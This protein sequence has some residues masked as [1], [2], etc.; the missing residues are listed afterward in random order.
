MD[1]ALSTEQEALVAATAEWCRDN[2][3]LDQARN[4]PDG[5]WAELEAMG[6]TAMT[7]PDMGLDHASETLV[8]AE[9][10][11]HLAPVGL[12]ASA[13]AARWTPHPGK[14]TLAL[15]DTA[16]PGG[17]LRVFDPEDA[18][19]ALGLVGHL[20]A[21]TLLPTDFG[22]RPS[23][24]PS[25]SLAHIDPA[26][27]FEAVAD[28]R[29]ALHLQLLAASYAVGCADA[30]RD[31]AAGYALIREQFERPIGWF[32]ALKHLCL[33]MAVRCAVARSQ[34]CYAACALNADDKDVSFHVA[35]A[36]QLADQAAL[37]NGRANIQVHGGIGM[38]DEA[39][40]HL[41]LKRAHLLSFIAP[42]RR[43]ILLGEAA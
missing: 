7:A 11:R 15:L 19:R 32:Q 39:S 10:G 20:A 17:T 29:A 24:D 9:L 30:A 6:W 1:L 13:V 8:F 23:L 38:T 3:P 37:E 33:D 41:C 34:L 42:A 16:A 2:L 12:L 18:E 4:R 21:T 35:S 28:Q 22:G 25:A 43:D 5:L 27:A 36:K 31:M 26:P 40:P 14:T